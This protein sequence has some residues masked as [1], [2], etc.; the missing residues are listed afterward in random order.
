[1][2]WVKPDE[3]FS[4][5]VAMALMFGA[6]QGR[7][8]VNVKEPSALAVTRPSKYSPCPPMSEKISTTAPGVV[9]PLSMRPCTSNSGDGMPLFAPLVVMM[10]PF[11]LP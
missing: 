7:V 8:A 5:S 9:V 1:M 6:R 11:P 2:L 3:L 4:V 10:P